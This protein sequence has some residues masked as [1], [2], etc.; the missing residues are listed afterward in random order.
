MDQCMVDI[1]LSDD[2]HLY[3]DVILFGPAPQGPD[4]EN[5][6]DLMGTIPYEVTCLIKKRVPRVYV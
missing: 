5:I 6:A 2:I 1:G 3:D 4:A